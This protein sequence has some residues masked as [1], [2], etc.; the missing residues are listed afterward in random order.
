MMMMMIHD[1][2]SDIVKVGAQTEHI[3]CKTSMDVV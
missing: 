2:F 3:T 1:K